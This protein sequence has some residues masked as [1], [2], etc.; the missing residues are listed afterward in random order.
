ML[1]R[2][3]IRLSFLIKASRNSLDMDTCENQN[4][5]K[6]LVVGNGFDLACGLKTGFTDFMAAIFVHYFK[7]LENCSSNTNSSNRFKQA[8]DELKLKYSFKFK[9][10]FVKADK[11]FF[12][13][14]FFKLLLHGFYPDVYLLY[15]LS[16]VNKNR[17][18]EYKFHECNEILNYFLGLKF[19]D[20]FKKNEY[21]WL[22]VEKLIGQIVSDNFNYYTIY[23]SVLDKAEKDEKKRN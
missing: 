2:L 21:K 22:D 19:N 12:E 6:I 17:I 10:N 16:E 9:I 5:N 1:M 20:L 23:N 3:F 18:S 8:I 15:I 13:N 14:I 11:R 4:V 7:Y